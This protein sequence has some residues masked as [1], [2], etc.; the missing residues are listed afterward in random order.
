MLNV[1]SADKQ[2]TATS[3]GSIPTVSTTPQTNKN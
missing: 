3:T 1:V 2:I